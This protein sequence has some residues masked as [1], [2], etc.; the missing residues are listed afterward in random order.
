MALSPLVSV[1]MSVYNG[2]DKLV[3]TIDSILEQKGVE[4]EFIIV[5]DGS[6]DDS[7]RILEE[8]SATDSRVR[9]ISQENRGLTRSLTIGC[10]AA[11]GE[12]I[13]RQ[14]AGDASL[15]GRLATQAEILRKQPD[16]V[17]VSCGS[18]FLGPDG[19]TL[20]E[21]RQSQQSAAEGLHQ[22]SLDGIKGPSHHGS[23]MFRKRDYDAVGGYR[24]HF[25][26]AQDLDLWTR[27]VERGR[28]LALQNVLY[29]ASV[30]SSSISCVKRDQQ[31]K[32]AELI[33]LGAQARR[34]GENEDVFLKR[35]QALQALPDN[36]RS[37]SARA[38]DFYYYLG[39][40][41]RHSDP[42]SAR[43]YYRRALASYPLHWKA[44]LRLVKTK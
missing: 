29:Q 12:L 24:Q 2:A 4:L 33:L 7:Y 15:P 11:G 26:V 30:C 13:A 32:T 23:T 5:D 17:M 8:Y 16:V 27:L 36:A 31:I 41:L 44:L 43:R 20:Y 35:A 6:T 39:S 22:L 18:R 10:A 28:H 37:Q 38:A 3:E 1:V 19:E 34:R 9:I 21:V 14:D 25:E 40:C 42:A